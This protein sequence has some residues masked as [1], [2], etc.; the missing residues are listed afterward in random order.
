[1]CVMRFWIRWN[2]SEEM[3]F[4]CIHFNIFVFTAWISLFFLVW[5]EMVI[6]DPI[7]HENWLQ[8]QNMK[9][10]LCLSVCLLYWDLKLDNNQIILRRQV[11][12]IHTHKLPS[13]NIAQVIKE[14]FCIFFLYLRYRCNYLQ[15]IRMHIICNFYFM[16]DY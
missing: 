14:I 13:T 7:I 4:V 2:L 16:S 10:S 9:L 6:H 1:M 12:V 11:V 8:L 15:D 3:P 5:G